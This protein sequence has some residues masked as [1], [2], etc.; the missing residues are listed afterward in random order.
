MPGRQRFGFGDVQHRTAEASCLERH[1][2]VIGDH[3]RAAGHVDQ[4]GVVRQPLEQPGVDQPDRLRC[5]GER[6]HQHV[7]LRCEILE[8]LRPHGATDPGTFAGARRTTS[9]VTSTAPAAGSGRWSP[10]PRRRS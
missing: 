6:Q 2:Q 7:R 1:G 10:L 5:Q 9:M 3:Q 8:L 4:P